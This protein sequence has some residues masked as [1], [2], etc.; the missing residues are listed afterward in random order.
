MGVSMKGKED[1]EWFEREKGVD[2][3]GQC[4]GVLR[5]RWGLG[6]AVE[7]RLD[8]FCGREL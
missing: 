7:E 6:M 5:D 3:L 1:N 2:L 4:W 8:V